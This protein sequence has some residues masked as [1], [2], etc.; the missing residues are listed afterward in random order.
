MNRSVRA[1]DAAS[2]DA[3]LLMRA[4]DRDLQERYP[5]ALIHS[6]DPATFTASGGVF[7]VCYEGERPVAC[8]ALRRMAGGSFEVKRM[9][10]LAAAR[11]RGH[12]RAILDALEARAVSRRGQVIR[13]ET[14]DRQPEAIRLYESAGYHPIPSYGEY[15]GSPHSRCFEKRL[16]PGNRI[17]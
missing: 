6:I 2:A 14:G 12:A 3:M 4:L 10:V 5:G 16:Q 15:E 17:L 9:F 1:V 13:L 8:G 7:L 11:R